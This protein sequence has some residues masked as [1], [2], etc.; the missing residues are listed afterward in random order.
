MHLITPESERRAY[1]AAQNIISLS[2]YRQ[3]RE[4][5]AQLQMTLSQAVMERHPSSP[6]K[7]IEA[8]IYSGQKKLQA[9][10]DLAEAIAHSC[11]LLVG[12][13]A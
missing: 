11:G 8:A 13:G 3:Q 6:C 2:R 12:D 9:G 10:A 4:R 5:L 7:R 1:K